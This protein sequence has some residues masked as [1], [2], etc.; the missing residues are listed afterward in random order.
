MEDEDLRERVGNE[1]N[2]EEMKQNNED[3]RG[4]A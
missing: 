4:D 1:E 2:D 3:R